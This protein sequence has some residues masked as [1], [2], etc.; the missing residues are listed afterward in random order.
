M[1]KKMLRIGTLCLAL[2]ACAF[3]FLLHEE[4]SAAS[5]KDVTITISDWLSTCTWVDF[6]FW[7]K[8]VSATDQTAETWWTINC[9]LL[10]W[11]GQYVR[12]TLSTL[13]WSA[14]ST[15][16]PNSKVQLKSTT[17]TPTG[18]LNNTALQTTYAAL[19]GVV[20]IYSKTST[21]VWTM[22]EWVSL[23]ITVPWGTAPDTYVWKLSLKIE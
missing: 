16:I 2:L 1:T 18:S 3:T 9:S 5:V 13:T 10:K 22:T 11:T 20:T 7:E 4:I 12:Y 8:N 19:S 15:V 23:K 6:N 14:T 21:Q 17:V